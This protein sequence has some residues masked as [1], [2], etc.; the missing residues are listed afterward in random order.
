V[1]L[2]THRVGGERA[3]RQACPLDRVLAF[4]DPLLARPAPVVEGN[5]PLCRAQQLGDDEADAGI[6]L[7]GVQIDGTEDILGRLDI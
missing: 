3:A 2:E 7:A 4:L 1:Q 5:D 6:E